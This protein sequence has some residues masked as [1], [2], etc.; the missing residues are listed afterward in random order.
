MFVSHLLVPEFVQSPIPYGSKK[1]GFERPVN[2]EVLSRLPNMHKD[3]INNVLTTMQVAQVVSA[4]Q[5]EVSIVFLK[6]IGEDVRIS[7]C[8]SFKIISV[9]VMYCHPL[10]NP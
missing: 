4:E 9:F 8:N 3:R 7:A 1:I 10:L 5:N 6:E 2:S